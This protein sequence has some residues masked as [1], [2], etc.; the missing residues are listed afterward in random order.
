MQKKDLGF[1]KGNILVIREAYKI[2][3]KVESFKDAIRQ[4]PGI[5]NIASSTALLITLISISY[6]AISA[7]RANP[8]GAIRYE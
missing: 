5:I 6:R 7:A 8:V 3:N 4:I 2:G 1:D